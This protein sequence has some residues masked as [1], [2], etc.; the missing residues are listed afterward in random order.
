[1]A[2]RILFIS[3][4]LRAGSNSEILARE[5]E[6]GA[7]EAGHE[8][9]FVSLKDKDIRFCKGCLACQQTHKCVI[10]DDAA[11]IVAKIQH[12][13]VLVF[14]TPIYYYE[15]SGQ[16]KTLLDRCNPLFPQQYAFREVYLLSTSAEGGDQVYA[17]A[18][19]GLQ[20][21]ISC[22]AHSRF[23]GNFSGGGI[24]DAREAISQPELLHQAYLFGRNL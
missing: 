24:N 9:H 5:A 16:L 8:V 11:A 20:G 14:A 13:D 22:F 15:L 2:K 4:S 17:G 3:S 6:R 12:S 1:M 18:V 19:N 10:D 7:R 23:A 21:W